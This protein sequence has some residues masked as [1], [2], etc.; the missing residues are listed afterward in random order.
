MIKDLEQNEQDKVNAKKRKRDTV[1]IAG[2]DS[3]SEDIQDLK[4]KMEKARAKKPLFD[5]KFKQANP[6][7]PSLKKRD[8]KAQGGHTIKHSGDHYKSKAGKGDVLK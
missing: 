1:Q 3:D 5:N 4:E 8:I 2:D 7:A 6:A